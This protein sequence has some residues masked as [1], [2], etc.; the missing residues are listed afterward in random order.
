MVQESH[1]GSVAL[2]AKWEEMVPSKVIKIKWNNVGTY[3]L[4]SL[5]HVL[6]IFFLSGDVETDSRY[7]MSC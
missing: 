7:A 4:L 6:S 2:S 1:L 3:P 5:G